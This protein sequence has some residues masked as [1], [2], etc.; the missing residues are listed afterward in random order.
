MKIKNEEQLLKH[1]KLKD[2]DAMN[3][4]VEIDNAV[5]DTIKARLAMMGW[6]KFSNHISQS[7]SNKNYHIWTAFAAVTP[8]IMPNTLV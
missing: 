1:R 5:I 7:I 4:K 8:L 3:K 6:L 2:Q